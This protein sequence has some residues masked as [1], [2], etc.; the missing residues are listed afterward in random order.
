MLLDSRYL[1]HARE[2]VLLP[3]LVLD[4][5]SAVGAAERCDAS[6]A[7]GAIR[8]ECGGRSEFT[9]RRLRALPMRDP[10][11]VL[12]F[13][14]VRMLFNPRFLWQSPGSVAATLAI[15]LLDQQI[16]ALGNVHR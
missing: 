6:M 9:L 16:A 15:I 1:R 3:V 5:T 2:A 10:F 13:V 14:S 8:P 12:F 4:S 11:A 7:L